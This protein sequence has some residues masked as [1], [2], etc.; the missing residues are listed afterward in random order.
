MLYGRGC[1]GSSDRAV[2][3]DDLYGAVALIRRH[4][5]GVHRSTMTDVLG[6]LIDLLDLSDWRR[7]LSR[8][9]RIWAGDLVWG[10][11]LLKLSRRQ[12]R[13]SRATDSL[14][15]CTPTF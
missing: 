11:S 9:V 6:D 1:K 7:S 12:P 13:P 8:R 4:G 10:T 15:P 5:M 2:L 3:R 14:I